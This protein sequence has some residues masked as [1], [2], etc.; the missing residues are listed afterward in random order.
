[1]TAGVSAIVCT[2]DASRW[3]ALER[4]VASLR[5]QTLEPLEVLVVVDHNPSLLARVQRELDGVVAVANRFGQGLSGARNSGIEAASGELVA[6][7]DDDATAAP[8]WLE[9]LAG[10]C[11]EQHVLGAGG[12]VDARW[13]GRRPP[14][15]PPEFLWVVGCTYEGVPK[16]PARVRNLYGGCFCIRRDVVTAIGGFRSELGRVGSNRMGCEETEL[17]IRAERASGGAGFWYEPAA[18]IVHDVPADRCTWS[19]FRSRC[20]AEGVSKAR[21]SRLVGADRG[22]SSE[23]AY[24][25]RALPSGIARGVRGALGG[26]EPAGLAQAAAIVAGLAVTAAGYAR[27]AAVGRARRVTA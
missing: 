21:L 11:A 10:V 22:L 5:G 7:L 2:H 18:V 6:F 20:F 1:V 17:C 23:R 4:A 12:R 25:R 13:L 3:P 19:Y 14:W 24:V 8:D 16:R 26:R 27:E 15:F 9:L